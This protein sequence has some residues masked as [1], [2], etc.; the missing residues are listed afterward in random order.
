MSFL[1]AAGQQDRA[2]E[3]L[4]GVDEVT[5]V[6]GVGSA[7]VLL[8][9]TGCAVAP[10]IS[11]KLVYMSPIYMFPTTATFAQSSVVGDRLTTSG[12]RCAGML[13]ARL[14]TQLPIIHF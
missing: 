4:R 10:F 13:L 3:L 9:G 11:T 2:A 12:L 1:D 14:G 5:L 8:A 7:G 6:G